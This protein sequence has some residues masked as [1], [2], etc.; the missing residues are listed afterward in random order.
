MSRV[1]LS[2]ID[3]PY[4]GSFTNLLDSDQYR[5]SA[6][7]V[8]NMFHQRPVTPNVLHHG[9]NVPHTGLTLA[10]SQEVSQ[11]RPASTEA[12]L[13]PLFTPLIDRHA[14]LTLHP[15]YGGRMLG[16]DGEKGSYGGGVVES[17]GDRGSYGAAHMMD[18]HSSSVDLPVSQKPTQVSE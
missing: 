6:N 9:S 2:A 5:E 12:P 1:S 4:R 18:T 10:T 13:K 17:G 3:A 8:P 7:S 15:Q 14:P 11:D 16:S